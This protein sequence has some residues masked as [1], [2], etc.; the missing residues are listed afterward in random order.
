MILLIINYRFTKN[1]SGSQL[2]LQNSTC[3]IQTEVNLYVM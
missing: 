3:L 2:Y 1:C